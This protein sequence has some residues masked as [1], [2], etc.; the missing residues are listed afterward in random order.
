M[1]TRYGIA[2]L[3]EL[4]FEIRTIVL[5]RHG[6]KHFLPPHL[7]NYRANIQAAKDLRVDFILATAAVGA[8]N[9]SLS[10]GTYVVLDQ[11][12][13]FTTSRKTTFF[14]GNDRSFRHTDMTNP[15]SLDVRK[16]LI[17][18]LRQNSLSKYKTRGTYV[19]TE[20]PRYETQAEIRMF[21][22]LGADVVGMTG[23]PEVVLA[24]EIGIPYG[25]LAYVTNMGAGMQAK[26]SQEEVEAQMLRSSED[27]KRIISS[28]IEEMALHK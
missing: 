5:I 11:F 27:M 23:V 22:K 19:C 13:D 25:T 26:I 3:A 15:Y 10:I 4:D 9:P 14:H 2:R 18:A 20:G 28:A 6:T 7:I 1:R 17:K 12:I 16:A 21:R 8:I 24:N